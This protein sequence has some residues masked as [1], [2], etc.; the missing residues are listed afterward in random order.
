VTDEQRR[1]RIDE[2]C[3]AALAREDGDRAAF[4]AHAC[5]DD[6]RLRQEV[7][8]LL[9]HAKTAER[10]LADPVASLAADVL[11]DSPTNSLLGRRI[12]SYS[13]LSRLGAGGMGEVYRARDPKLERDVAI[14]VLPSSLAADPTRRARLSREARLLATL[15][16]P[17][18]AAV[19]GLEE[20]AGITALVMELVEGATLAET[21]G[22]ARVGQVENA[23]CQCRKR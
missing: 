15:N 18:I 19:Y 5:G 6:D 13:I 22:Q 10:F 2:V 14:K 21:L 17:H 12:G 7:E 9:A 1:R 8:A 4:V 11:R 16:H 20:S 23:L 3:D